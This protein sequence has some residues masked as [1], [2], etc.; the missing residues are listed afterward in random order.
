ME[1][2]EKAGL[3]HGGGGDGGDGGDGGGGLSDGGGG[4]G[5]NLAARDGGGGGGDGDDGGGGLSDG[6][7]GEG[8]DLAAGDGGGGGGDGGDGDDGGGGLSDGGGGEGDDLAATFRVAALG[9]NGGGSEDDGSNF[10][11]YEWAKQWPAEEEEGEALTPIWR[12]SNDP[13]D[14]AGF[15]VLARDAVCTA[16]QLCKAADGSI[17]RLPSWLPLSADTRALLHPDPTDDPEYASEMSLPGLQG[18]GCGQQLW[19]CYSTSRET[20]AHEYR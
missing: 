6:G 17:V 20:L 7:G 1:E 12:N 8:D 16:V 13:M 4:E 10:A 14:A 19:A 18:I 9:G 3:S 5:D 2:E 11:A 15:V